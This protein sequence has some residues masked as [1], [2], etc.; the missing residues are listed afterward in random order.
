M[1][2]KEFKEH[3]GIQM[4]DSSLMGMF[5]VVT[6]RGGWQGLAGTVL[7]TW[8]VWVEGADFLAWVPFEVKTPSSLWRP[9]WE[10]VSG[11]I[12]ISGTEMQGVKNSKSMSD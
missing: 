4:K 7:V 10:D 9:S 8:V 6:A 11:L 1:C 2:E 3:A 12:S 5:E